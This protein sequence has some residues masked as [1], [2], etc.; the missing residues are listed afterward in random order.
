MASWPPSTARSRDPLRVRD[1]N[2]LVGQDVG[3]I[4]VHIAA[5]VADLA[6]AGE[7]LVSSTTKELVAGPGLRFVERGT[8]RLKGISDQWRL[9][10]AVP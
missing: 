4:A 5:R 10:A 8:R 9:F 1:R 2:E 6:A 3:G 7:V